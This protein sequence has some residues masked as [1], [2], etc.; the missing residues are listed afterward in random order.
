MII[1]QTKKLLVF[2][3]AAVVFTACRKDAKIQ[4]PENELSEES[5]YGKGGHNDRDTDKGFVYTLGNQTDDNK[6][7]IYRRNK[8]GKL[9]Y[10]ASESTGGKGTGGGLGNQGAVILVEKRDLLLA[11]NPG[12][13]T[14]SSFKI[15]HSGLHLVSQV[16][17]GGEQPV[18]ITENDGVVYVLNSGGEGNIAGFRLSYYGKLYPIHNSKRPLSSTMAGGAQVSFVLDGRVLVITEKATNKIITYTVNHFGYPG[19]FHSITAANATPFGF[20]TGRFGKIY[21]SEAAGGAE[22]AS[23]LSSYQVYYNGYIRLITGPVAT[24]QSAACWV[25]LTDNERYAYTT[26][27]GSNSVSSFSANFFGKIEL[28]EAAAGMTEA[29]PIDADFSKNSR[30]MYVLNAGSQSISVFSVAHN[31]SLTSIQTVSDLPAGATGMA[32]D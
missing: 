12:S 5:F 26:N 27:T 17:S 31:G 25:V 19:S 11:V 8:D 3:L 20:A 22:G 6:V 16:Y 14:I 29:G 4:E 30:Y 13:N 21:V 23:T 9:S 2:A 7:L 15:T 18:S 1:N 32:A 24:N 28:E 10:V